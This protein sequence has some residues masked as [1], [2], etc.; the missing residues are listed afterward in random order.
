M[1][2]TYRGP[3]PDEPPSSAGLS[4]RD[5]FSL[6]AATTALAATVACERKGQT[7]VVHTKRRSK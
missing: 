7:T 3:T 4:R 6:V 5:F 2:T 1:G